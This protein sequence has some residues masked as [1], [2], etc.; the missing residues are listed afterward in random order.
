MWGLRLGAS[1]MASWHSGDVTDT[2]ALL[3]DLDRTLVDLQSYTN[4]A[5]ALADVQELVGE[6]SD[7]DVPT[8]DWDRATMSCMSV[9][10]A[11]FGDARWSQISATI[12]RHERAA[13]PQS[14]LMPTV[15][16]C[17]GRLVSGPTAVITLLPGDVARD[18]LEFHDLRMGQEIDVVVGRDPAMRP[19]P[20]PDG[21]IEA[22]RILGVAPGSATMVG[23]S[24]WDAQAALAAG[25]T[26]VGVPADGFEGDMRERVATAPTMDQALQG[27]GRE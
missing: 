8:T 15:Q 16:E 18:V 24:T 6:W 12:A 7:V 9:L 23:D 4:Y 5:A 19:K 27:L 1:T 2:D 13:I 21:V 10:H 11:F 14:D 3:L 20:E 17:F 25:A 22:C 26:F